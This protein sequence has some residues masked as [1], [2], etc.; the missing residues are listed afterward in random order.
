M[1]AKEREA[2]DH[3]Y[4]EFVLEQVKR[5]GDMQAKA[6]RIYLILVFACAAMAAVGIIMGRSISGAISILMFGLGF[7]A[8]RNASLKAAA[9][10]SEAAETIRNAIDDPDFDIPDDYPEDILALR[11]V[12]SPTLKIIRSQLIAYGVCAVM[13]WLGTAG[14]VYASTVGGF[15]PGIFVFSFVM[16]AMAVF[17]TILTVRA[18]KDLPIARAYEDYLNEVA[19]E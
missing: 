12:V 19:S 17:L 10:V 2:R 9:S 13:L 15:S 4:E 16:G 8:A 1:D 14:I 7:L 11:S 6:G 18:W 3:R 5:Y